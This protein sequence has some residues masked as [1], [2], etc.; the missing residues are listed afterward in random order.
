MTTLQSFQAEI[1]DIR[2]RELARTRA[3]SSP[4]TLRRG[5]IDHKPVTKVRKKATGSD[6]PT[7]SPVAAKPARDEPTQ[8]ITD[9]ERSI[10]VRYSCTSPVRPSHYLSL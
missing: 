5:H 4:D 7:T 3:Q 10:Q 2:N 6:A 9:I 1:E 8:E